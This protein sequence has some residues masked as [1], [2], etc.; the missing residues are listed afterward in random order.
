MKIDTLLNYFGNRGIIAL[1]NQN[2]NKKETRSKS[3]PPKEA[4]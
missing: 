1:S 3:K 2:Q 4:A